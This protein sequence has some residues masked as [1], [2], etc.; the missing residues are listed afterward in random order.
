VASEAGIERAAT[1][2]LHRFEKF[3]DPSVAHRAFA[4]V[5][6]DGVLAARGSRRD[7]DRAIDYLR[8]VSGGA[9]PVPAEE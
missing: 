1:K 9:A 5:R 3:S 7:T 2:V 4:L 8:H 6:P